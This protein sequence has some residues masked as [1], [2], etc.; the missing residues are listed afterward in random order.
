MTERQSFLIVGNGIA[1][2]TAAEILRNEDSAAEITVVADDPFPVYYRPALKDYLGGKIREDKLWARPIS[3]YQDRGIRFLNDR[4]VGIEVAKHSVLLGRGQGGQGVQGGQTLG[5][6]RLLLAHGA[7]ASTLT[8]PGLNL[9]GVTTL[10]TVADYQKVLS[11]LHSVRRVVITGSGT[12]ALESIETLRH[13][14]FHVTHLLRRRSLWSEVLDPTASDLVL[15]QETRDGVDV[16]YEQEIAEIVGH[17][18]KVSAIVTTTG[19][20]IPC[21]AV[22]LGIGIEPIIDFVKS[23]GIACGRGVKVDGAMHTNAPDIYAA[24]DLIET[25]DPLTGRSRVI[26]QWYPSIQQARAAAYSM[27]DILDANHHFRFGN[28]YNASMLY[29]LDFA[30]VGL[31]NVP[32]DGKG[33]Q[34]II[35]DPQPRT[36]QKVILKDGVPVGMLALGDRTKVLAFKRAVD[37]AVD[38]SPVA[39]RLFAPDFKLGAWLDAQGVPPPILGVSRE[40]AVAI[41]QALSAVRT[42]TPPAPNK[43]HK[44][45]GLIEAILVPVTAS[46]P[47]EVKALLKETYLSQTKVVTIGR[48]EGSSIP[49]KHSSISRRHAEISYANGHYVLRDLQSKNGTFVNGQRLGTDKDAVSLL[50]PGDALRFGDVSFA[51]QT[52]EVDPSAS[53]LLTKQN[54]HLLTRGA[55]LKHKGTEVDEVTKKAAHDS[56]VAEKTEQKEIPASPPIIPATPAHTKRTALDQPM[57]NTDGSVL[58]PGASSAVP[59]AVIATMNETPALVAIVQGKSQVFLLK[60]GKSAIIGRDKGNPVALADMSVSRRHAEIFPGPNGMTIRDL[61]SSN[62]VLVNQAR[63]DNPYRLSHGDRINIGSVVAYFVDQRAQHQQLSQ[64]RQPVT[65][66]PNSDSSPSA[67][68]NKQCRRCGSVTNTIARFCQTCGAPL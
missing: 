65:A 34:E 39:A 63:I 40:G 12:L 22:L 37:A 6:S 8:C 49:V 17:D 61:G 29:G 18:G 23:A 32:K 24:G 7:R 31:S 20:H 10:R 4:V 2:V 59:A 33:Y 67:A 38:L 5:Y 15:Q 16:R 42:N 47:P 9:A 28:F 43:L 54:L 60:Q 30:S 27:L 36:Y 1:G 19:V 14:G 52:R 13:R 57:L 50:K 66:T 62:G 11:H 45:Q 55:N 48:A 44:P 68:S 3:F 56:A 26:G 25:A 58:F 51:F 53:M 41:K 35:A 46:A 21:E 64:S